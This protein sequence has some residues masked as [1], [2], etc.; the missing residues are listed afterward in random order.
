MS[1]VTKKLTRAFSLLA[2]VALAAGITACDSSTTVV[3]TVDVGDNSVPH[4]TQLVIK[5]SSVADPTRSLS[6]QFISTTPG[7]GT[8][9]G[10]PP[11]YLPQ[12]DTF[13]IEP[14][15]LS[16]PVLVEAQG[17]EIYGGEVLASGSVTA[18]VVAQQ[19][20]AVTV[21]LR[22]LGM[23][24]APDGGVGDAGSA[25]DGSADGARD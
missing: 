16:G 3:V 21:T 25:C 2:V 5:I 4:F 18:D 19:K 13:T 9:G 8:E 20:T 10:L 6:Q 11:I 12:Q 14:S 1:R 7:Y 15:Y 24:C 17:L 23:A 22:G